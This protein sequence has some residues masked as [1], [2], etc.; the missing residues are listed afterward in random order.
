MNLLLGSSL[1][2]DF[3]RS[4]SPTAFKPF[5][6]PWVVET[7]GPSGRTGA[8]RGAAL[9]QPGLSMPTDLWQRAP[10]CW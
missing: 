1:W 6:A 10:S 2:I 9:H 4:R 3:R 5:I 8:L 7:R